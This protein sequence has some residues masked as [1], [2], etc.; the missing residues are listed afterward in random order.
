MS[1]SLRQ[2]KTSVVSKLS[3]L[4]SIQGVT[5]LWTWTMDYGLLK[6]GL[7][8]K[9]MDSAR[10]RNS[11]RNYGLAHLKYGL[12]TSTGNYGLRLMAH[13]SETMDLRT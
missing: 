1:V 13:L 6:Y 2:Y 9:T 4:S 8:T 5:N 3:E 11:V 10:W 7:P 12:W